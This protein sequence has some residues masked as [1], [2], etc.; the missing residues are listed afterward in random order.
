MLLNRRSFFFIVGIP[1]AAVLLCLL[2]GL[3][4]SKPREQSEAAKVED[5]QEVRIVAVEEKKPKPAVKKVET[6]KASKTQK[7]KSVEQKKTPPAAKNIVIKT[8]KAEESKAAPKREPEKKQAIPKGKPVLVEKQTLSPATYQLDSQIIDEGLRLINNTAGLVPIVEASYQQIGF[9]TYLRKM[10]DMGGQLFIGAPEKRQILARVVLESQSRRGTF[11]FFGLDTHIHE[12]LNGM[13]LFRPREITNEPLIREILNRS[14]EFFGEEDL[15]V[16]ILLP[17]PTEG[18]ILG[19]LTKYLT[20]QGIVI[21]E[22]DWV[23]GQYVEKG[24]AFLLRLEKARIR[25]TQQIVRLNMILE[26]K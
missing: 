7:D 21:S 26:M 24:H 22:L 2:L 16:V 11:Q 17:L 8:K 23:W 13:A 20:K 5:L 4:R 1:I 14:F 25:K 19:A 15:C 9:Q 6:K 12:K 10:F 3:S 18:G